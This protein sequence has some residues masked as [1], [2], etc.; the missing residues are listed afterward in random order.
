MDILVLPGT[1]FFIAAVGSGLLAL[2]GVLL[3][4]RRRTRWAGIRL[5]PSTQGMA[6]RYLVGNA[7]GL[8]LAAVLI[9]TASVSNA[10]G[11]LRLLLLAGALSAY[12]YLAL[13]IPRRPIVQQ[14][15]AAAN[16]RRLTPGF[17]S[18]VRVGLRS[19]E[20]PLEILRR[21]VLRPVP[22]WA[23]IQDLVT[24]SIALGLDQRLRPFAAVNVVARQRGCRE[25]MDVAEAL[26]QAE[27]EGGSML[28]VLEAQ[29]TTLELI[30][31]SEF[32]RMLRRRTMYLLLMVA[33]AL[34]IGILLNLLFTMTAGGSVLFGLGA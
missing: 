5:L 12:L 25:L 16:L 6:G 10:Q 22:R 24:E 1:P 7:L 34:V 20:S 26:A 23:P 28:P 33:L 19:F 18:F 21:Y 29:Q 30:L 13:V 8:P 2:L 15:R 9:L 14:Q 11:S 17:I 4:E 32:K 3:L 27:A 31:Q